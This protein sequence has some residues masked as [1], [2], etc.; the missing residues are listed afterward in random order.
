[1]PS[2]PANLFNHP[3]CGLSVFNGIVIIKSQD[4]GMA[5]LLHSQTVPSESF[6]SGQVVT[7][8]ET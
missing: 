5:K 3:R 1:M 6:K 2:L 8:N 4:T 7:S